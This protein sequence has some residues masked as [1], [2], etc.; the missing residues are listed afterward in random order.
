[1]T[2]KKL[3]GRYMPNPETVRN[4]KYLRCF[5][6]LV[7]NP[8]LGHLNRHS[9]ANA[10][11]VGLFCAFMPIPFQMVLAAAIAIMVKSNIPVSVALVWVTN[12]V[13]MPPLFYLSYKVGAWLLSMPVEHFV[14]ESSLHWV[15]NSMF[16]IWQ[17]FILGCFA[18]G[19][20]FAVA[21]WCAVHV[22]WQIMVSK[23]WRG[24]H[25]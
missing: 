21:S 17:P 2:P 8:G 14:F 13:T 5:G 23:K 25:S 9:V 11:A 19:I 10:F 7:A 4:H 15:I 18:L 16:H 22:T 6:S 1:M 24:R 20:F 12:P 3:I